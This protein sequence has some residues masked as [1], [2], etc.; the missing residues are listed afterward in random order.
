MFKYSKLSELLMLL[1]CNVIIWY[2]G[3]MIIQTYNMKP[4][5]LNRLHWE[6]YLLCA[7]ICKL[8]ISYVEQLL[9]FYKRHKVSENIRI[10]S[11]YLYC[12]WHTV[13]WAELYF[14]CRTFEVLIFLQPKE[15][16]G[17]VH[18]HGAAISFLPSYWLYLYEYAT[19]VLEKCIIKRNVFMEKCIFAILFFL[20]KCRS[21][22]IQKDPIIYRWP[23]QI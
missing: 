16:N 15:K 13:F 21:N 9:S 4:V 1:V 10:I 8:A 17:W 22:A 5:C 6:Y 3:K 20:E 12:M 19:I 23:P 11:F 14:A 7:A 18:F 2:N